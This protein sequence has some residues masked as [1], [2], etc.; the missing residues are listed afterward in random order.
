[1]GFVGRLARLLSF[2]RI[3]SN[4]SGVPQ[5]DVKVNPSGGDNVTA[6]HMA[7]P[8]DDAYPLDLDYVYIAPLS[9]ANRFVANGYADVV[10]QPRAEKGD[11]RIYGRRSDTG[12]W[13]NEVWLKSD[14]TI[15]INNQVCSTTMLPTGTVITTN[16][17]ATHTIASSGQISG[18]NGAG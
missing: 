17:T 14:G 11:K 7:D 15:F 3:P 5:S 16:G 10:N 6:D 13:V 12:E 2:N 8:G 18:V 4:H 9:R 1:M